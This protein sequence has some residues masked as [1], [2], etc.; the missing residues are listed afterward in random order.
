MEKSPLLDMRDLRPLD[1]PSSE[2]VVKKSELRKVTGF[3]QYIQK[4]PWAET[5]LCQRKWVM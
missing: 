5:R 3:V 4:L 2:S 1:I